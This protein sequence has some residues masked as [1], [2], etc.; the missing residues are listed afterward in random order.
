MLAT[1]Y[2]PEI[3]NL[4]K[5]AWRADPAERLGFIVDAADYYRALKDVLPKAEKTVWII[6]WDF[7]PDIRLDP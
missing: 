6:G 5:N 3:I 7:D 2:S 4:E 1:N